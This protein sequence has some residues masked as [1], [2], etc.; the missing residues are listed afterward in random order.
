MSRNLKG[1]ARIRRPI[2]P[3]GRMGDASRQW[4]GQNLDRAVDLWHATVYLC[5]RTKAMGPV[6]QAAKSHSAATFM[7]AQRAFGNY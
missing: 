7:D 4:V 6:A 2:A 1:A 3:R 5:K